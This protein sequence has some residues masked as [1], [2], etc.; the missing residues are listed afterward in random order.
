MLDSSNSYVTLEE[1]NELV[2][3]MY[4]STSKERTIWS[5]LSDD[6]KEILILNTMDIVDRPQLLYIGTKVDSNQDLEWPRVINGVS[7]QVP[8]SIKRG[9]MKQLFINNDISNSKYQELI[10]NNIKS[11]A[12]GG[13][14]KIEF[15]TLNDSLNTSFKNNTGISKNIWKSYFQQWS[16]ITG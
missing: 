13:G 3:K 16:K 5:N 12:D 1:A 2:T 14:A 8:D 6:D 11:Y 4:L 15:A 10:N 7:K 9:M